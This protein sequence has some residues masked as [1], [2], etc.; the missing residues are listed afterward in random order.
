MNW[1]RLAMA[2]VLWPGLYATAVVF[3]RVLREAG[4]SG[5]FPWMGAGVFGGGFCLAM[6]AYLFLPRPQGIYVLGHELTHA[7]AVMLSGGK[8]HS[9]QVAAKGGKVVADRTSPWIS[10]APYILPFYPIVFGVLWLASTKIWP[11]L[12][13]YGL[14]FLGLWAAVWG[15]HYAFTLGLLPTRQPDF[16]AYGRIFSLTLILFGNLLLTGWITWWVLRPLPV[17]ATLVMLGSEWAWTYTQLIHGASGLL[18]R[19]LPQPA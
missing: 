19:Y 6:V 12:N 9:L 1:L 13:P 2:I 3:G 15:Y 8:V 7:L 16:L 17:G 14:V 5:N 11:E 18:L 10:L 4:G